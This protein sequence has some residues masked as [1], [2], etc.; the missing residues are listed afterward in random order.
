[1]FPLSKAKEKNLDVKTGAPVE[2]LARS[3]AKQGKNNMKRQNGRGVGHLKSL[4]KEI[5]SKYSHRPT[6]LNAGLGG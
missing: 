2:C 5:C 3:L 4:F 1:M 6:S